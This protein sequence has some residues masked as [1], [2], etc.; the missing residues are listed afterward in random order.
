MQEQHSEHLRGMEDVRVR[1]YQYTDTVAESYG[2]EYELWGK[3]VDC[4]R[5]QIEIGGNIVQRLDTVQQ[6]ARVRENVIIEGYKRTRRE[7]AVQLNEMGAKSLAVGLYNEAV[8]KLIQAADL[9]PEEYA[10]RINLGWAYLMAGQSADARDEAMKGIE[11]AETATEA[12]HLLGH[13]EL[14]EGNAEDAIQAFE[15]AKELDPDSER[16][17]LGLGLAYM[18]NEEYHIALNHWRRIASE[19]PVFKEYSLLAP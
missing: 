19:V 10:I 17:A 8:N 1:M 3:H 9:C 4:D 5:S 13:V 7:K 18:A 6:L 12:Y 11:I 14:K 2:S 15:K 16:N